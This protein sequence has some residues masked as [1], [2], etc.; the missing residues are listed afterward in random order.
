[1][2]DVGIHVSQADRLGGIGVQLRVAPQRLGHAFIILESDWRQGSQQTR[3]EASALLLWQA[4]CLS[5]DLINAHTNPRL[6]P[7]LWPVNWVARR[8]RSS[9][10]TA[11][12]SAVRQRLAFH[13]G[14]HS[15]MPPRPGSRG[16]SNQGLTIQTQI[17][18]G[19]TSHLGVI[20]TKAQA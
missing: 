16:I 7:D 2:L 5:R 11:C 14:N 15:V 20:S 9:S 10:F 6:M 4:Q 3:G 18:G 13:G 19:H 1:M 8:Y 17:V 12:R